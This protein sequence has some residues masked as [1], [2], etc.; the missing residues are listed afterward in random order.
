MAS[1]LAAL[2]AR[3]LRL[4]NRGPSLDLSLQN[5][6]YVAHRFECLF[7]VHP[8]APSGDGAK[9]QCPNAADAWDVCDPG[10]DLLFPDD[11]PPAGQGQGARHTAE[12][13]QT[14]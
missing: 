5:K 7:G 10:G 8:T 14:G 11:P 13:S 9:S 6:Q 1:S 4:P 3:M 12:R 2:P